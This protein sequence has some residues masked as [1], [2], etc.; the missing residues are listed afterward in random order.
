[1]VERFDAG[2]RI[3][4]FEHG[5]SIFRELERRDGPES[6]TKTSLGPENGF[7]GNNDMAA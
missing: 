1:M 3:Q 7:K 4:N 6:P 5:E 2:K